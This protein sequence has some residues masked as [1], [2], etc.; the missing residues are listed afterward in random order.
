MALLAAIKS[1]SRTMLLGTG[2]SPRSTGNVAILSDPDLCDVV[3]MFVKNS[4]WLPTLTHFSNLDYLFQFEAFPCILTHHH[5]G[6]LRVE[7]TRGGFLCSSQSIAPSCTVYMVF[8]VYCSSS[9]SS[10][11]FV[12]AVFGRC[13]DKTLMFLKTPRILLADW[14]CVRSC[15]IATCLHV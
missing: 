6:I 4:L 5:Q 9:I 1:R 13:K 11:V 3:I 10:I 12:F 2:K 14:S 8:L 15:E 7:E